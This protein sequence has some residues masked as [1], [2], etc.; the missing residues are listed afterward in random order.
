MTLKP[1]LPSEIYSS[2]RLSPVAAAKIDPHFIA[3]GQVR[4]NS[5][6]EA[7]EQHTK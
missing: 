3:G 2:C 4:N 7:P 1:T 5:S 6:R